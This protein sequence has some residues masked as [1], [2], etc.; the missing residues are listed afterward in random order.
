MALVRIFVEE[1]L[2]SVAL[3]IEV[4]TH[5]RAR[6]HCALRAIAIVRVGPGWPSD[7]PSVLNWQVRLRL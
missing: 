1:E 3:Q 5:V 7:A 4:V 6:L 2:L